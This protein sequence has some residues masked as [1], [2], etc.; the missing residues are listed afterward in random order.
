MKN[1]KDNNIDKYAW[2]YSD[3]DEKEVY[4]IVQYWNTQEKNKTK[5]EIKSIMELNMV[6]YGKW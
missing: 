6:L 5:E 4:K 3:I 2:L 1:S